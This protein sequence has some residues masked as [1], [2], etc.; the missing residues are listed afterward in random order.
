MGDV[1]W[2]ALVLAG[3]V[4]WLLWRVELRVRRAEA[5]VKHAAPR[6][7]ELPRAVTSPRGVE[8]IPGPPS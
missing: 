3:V 8:A 6:S 2:L 4:P 5:G 1:A 7:R